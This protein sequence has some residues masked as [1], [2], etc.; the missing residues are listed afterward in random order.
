MK[1]LLIPALLL[2][3]CQ[4]DTEKQQIKEPVVIDSVVYVKQ[5]S[6]MPP[7]FMRVYWKFRAHG[8][9]GISNEPVNVGDTINL[10]ITR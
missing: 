8:H 1:L 6:G 7:T 2:A 5:H 9:W 4:I 10:V 3:S